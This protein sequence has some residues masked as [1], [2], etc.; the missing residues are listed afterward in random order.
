MNLVAEGLQFI[1]LIIFSPALGAPRGIAVDTVNNRVLWCDR[2]KQEIEFV[3]FDGTSRGV[4]VGTGLEI[5]NDVVVS[6]KNGVVI[7]C[8]TGMKTI[9]RS[10]LN[11]TGRVVIVSGIA[12]MISLA[13][14]YKEERVYWGDRALQRIESVYLDGSDRRIHVTHVKD[15][16]SFDPYG[17]A[18]RGEQDAIHF[19]DF[20]TGLLYRLKP[21]ATE[22]MATQVKTSTSSP[23]PDA[24]RMILFI[25]DSATTTS[26]ITTS[27]T[28]DHLT[29]ASPTTLTENSITTTQSTTTAESITEFSSSSSTKS[30]SSP[31]SSSSTSLMNSITTTQ[32]ITTDEP[33]TDPLIKIKNSKRFALGV[34][35]CVR[36]HV[37]STARVKTSIQCAMMCA[38]INDC[39]SFNF[40]PDGGLCELNDE[41]QE[42]VLDDIPIS[43][44]PDSSC[45]YFEMK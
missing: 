6:N 39:I 34:N 37:I 23:L 10:Y 18:L 26:I 9:E 36:N 4:L 19:T 3:D 30:T 5:P 29:T 45:R 8:D 1:F 31:P 40:H 35:V 27:S 22:P 7:W 12:N 41:I 25:S 44:L 38:G 28:V 2:G 33:I 16:N 42:D 20:S 32:S 15:L 11:G 21:S 43:D 13:L 24:P 14:D 17:I